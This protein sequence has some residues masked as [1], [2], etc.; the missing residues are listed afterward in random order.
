MHTAMRD[1]VHIY[2]QKD[3]TGCNIKVY[4]SMNPNP[5]I[6]VSDSIMKFASKKQKRRVIA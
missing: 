1:N 2:M 4:I 6:E 5:L 3:V